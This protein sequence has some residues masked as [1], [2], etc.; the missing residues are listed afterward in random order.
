MFGKAQAVC[1]QFLSFLESNQSIGQGIDSTSVFEWLDENIGGQLQIVQLSPSSGAAK[2]ADALP[3]QVHVFVVKDDQAVSSQ[4]SG[5]DY[6]L[7][8]IVLDENNKPIPGAKVDYVV[9]YVDRRET[10]AMPLPTNADGIV[11]T[12]FHVDLLP[13]YQM[14]KVGVLVNTAEQQKNAGTAFWGGY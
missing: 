13:T 2:A 9:E 10:H 5:R 3:M 12:H 6:Q 4:T 1:R 14:V 11:S 8:V 7:F